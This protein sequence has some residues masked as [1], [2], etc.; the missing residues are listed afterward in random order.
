M[1]QPRKS[2]SSSGSSRRRSSSASGTKRSS[3][4]KSAGGKKAAA[5]KPAAKKATASRGRS[6]AASRSGGASRSGAS[7]SSARKRRSPAPA[8]AA[9]RTTNAAQDA[10]AAGVASGIVAL[11]DALSSRAAES[12][13][14]VMLTRERL[15][16]A[17]DGAVE[18]GHM[19]QETANGLATE[20]VRRSRREAA[21]ILADVEQLAGR[22]RTGL[23]QAGKKVRSSSAADRA[24]QQ[25]DR[26]RRTA[27]VGPNFPVLGYDDLNAAQISDRLEGLTPAELRKV[28]DYER[29][30]GNRKTVLGAIERKLG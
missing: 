20:I 2:S 3:S 24:L 1:P 22:S 15:Q 19:T 10:D 11:R 23:E 5:K 8:T 26:A 17:F 9:K 7:S 13:N 27:G 29:R 4:A 12:L 16:E 25:V 14:L 28:R 6:T 21:D 18:R 30:H